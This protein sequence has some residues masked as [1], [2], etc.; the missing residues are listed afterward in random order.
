MTFII[1]FQLINNQNC[2]DNLI[3]LQEF[4][5]W[6]NNIIIFSFGYF[7]KTLGWFNHVRLD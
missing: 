5:Q 2:C 4:G 3:G 7:E 6:F 1:G